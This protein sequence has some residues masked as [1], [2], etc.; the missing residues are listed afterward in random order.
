MDIE[1]VCGCSGS[2]QYFAGFY[3]GFELVKAERRGSNWMDIPFR[4]DQVQY[5]ADDSFVSR[6]ILLEYMNRNGGR[7]IK[8]E[9]ARPSKRQ[10]AEEA[11]ALLA[12]GMAAKRKRGNASQF[13]PT[14][15]VELSPAQ[16][17]TQR[18][19]SASQSAPPVAAGT[20]TEAA[21]PK[22]VG[23]R[24]GALGAGLA[25]GALEMASA[26]GGCYRVPDTRSRPVSALRN[27]TRRRVEI[28]PLVMHAVRAC[29]RQRD[30]PPL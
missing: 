25:A 11:D 20:I 3:L 19:Y 21:Q 17:L 30:G 23:Q 2:L 14:V 26:V 15:A 28:S 12:P 6:D 10:L 27:S 13:A 5:A 22:V 24:A 18:R 9:R 4:L 16:R 7:E 1:T 8:S 29:Q